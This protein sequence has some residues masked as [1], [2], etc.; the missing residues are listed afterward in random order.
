MSDTTRNQCETVLTGGGRTRVVRRGEIVHRDSGPWSATV[1]DLLRYLAGE[2]F[3][4]APQVVEPGF[5]PAGNETLTFVEGTSAHPGPWPRDLLVTI[6]ATM[7][8]LHQLTRDYQPP[9][10]PIWQRWFGRDL[11]GGTHVIGHCDAAPWNILQSGGKVALIDWETAGPVD[12]IVELAHVCW[13]NAQLHDDDVAELQGLGSPAE[14]AADL[15]AI[16][17]GYGLPSTKRQALPD[18]MIEIA[19]QDAADQARSAAITEQTTESTELWAI[20]WR[21]RAASWML[22]HRRTLTNALN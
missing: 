22:T 10:T 19:V 6:G 20:T 21:T 7:R 1:L 8:Q 13:L 12:P 11:G 5:D 4:A 15:R 3:A 17:D 2:G 9:A 14:R 18:L 16:V